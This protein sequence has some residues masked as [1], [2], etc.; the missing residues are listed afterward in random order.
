MGQW[1]KVPSEQAKRSKAL[2]DFPMKGERCQ[3]H[4]PHTMSYIQF[5][6]FAERTKEKQKQCIRCGYW[7]FDSEF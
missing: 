7:F 5:Q 3:N 2:I 1:G 6:S 4:K